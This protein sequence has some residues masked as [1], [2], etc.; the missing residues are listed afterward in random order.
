MEVLLPLHDKKDITNEFYKKIKV[1]KK[2]GLMVYISTI[3]IRKNIED[4]SHFSDFII[5]ANPDLWFWNYPIPTKKE[6]ITWQDVQKLIKKIQTHPTKTKA[7]R[8]PLCKVPRKNIDRDIQG[9]KNCGPYD[10]LVVSPS[11]EVHICNS[12]QNKLGTLDDSL[13]KI[14]RENSIVQRFKTHKILPQ[15][16]QKCK[17]LKK[18]YGGCRYSAYLHTKKLGAKHP[19]MKDSEN[20]TSK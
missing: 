3:A 15:E 5:K 9:C 11:G 12:F 13:L 1:L 14:W 16:C 19:L 10:H 8:F 20:K 2:K 7:I 18:C 4:F 6:L 17:L